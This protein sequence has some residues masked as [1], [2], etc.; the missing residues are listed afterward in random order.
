MGVH[1]RTL[2]KI[3]IILMPIKQ[4]KNK[5][6]STE[7]LE[8]IQKEIEYQ[9]E[10]VEDTV[11]PILI[12]EGVVAKPVQIECSFKVKLCLRVDYDLHKR[13]LT[14]YKLNLFI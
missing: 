5:K 12:T 2:H 3:F 6:Q 1:L 14:F 10:S 8:S 11:L 4:K 7:V 13:K 9:R